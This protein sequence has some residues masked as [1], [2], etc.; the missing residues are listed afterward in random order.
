MRAM[1]MGMVQGRVSREVDTSR[2][3][4]PN[5]RSPVR[6]PGRSAIMAMYCGLSLTV[7]ATAVLY[8][9]HATGNL[10]ARH[11]RAGYPTYS[12]A[13]INTAVTT[14]LIWLSA[15][16]VLGIAAWL[17]T[18]RTI[19]AR[20]PWARSTA[21]ATFAIGT[22]IALFDLLVKDTSGQTGLPPLLGWV[23]LLPCGAGL[24][25]IALLWRAW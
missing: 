15:V 14:Y 1:H 12:P 8:I 9:D 2:V 5:R 23:G 18:V 21:S 10:L 24:L 3:V 17:W 11:I 13:R 22:G 25:A 19:K 20:K 4:D 16:G 6:G 7:G